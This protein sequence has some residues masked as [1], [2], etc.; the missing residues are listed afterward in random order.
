EGDTANDVGAKI[1]A[2]SASNPATGSGIASWGT[3]TDAGAN[4]TVNAWRNKWIE[5]TSGTGVGQVRLIHSNTATV[6]TTTGRWDTVPDSTSDFKIFDVTARVTGSD[7]GADTTPVRANGFLV[8][9]GQK[10]VFIK[11][12]LVNYTVDANIK[13]DT[14]GGVTV[15]SCHSRNSV[16]MLWATAGAQFSALRVASTNVQVASGGF[17]CLIEGGA[18]APEI[19]GSRFTGDD[20]AVCVLVRSGSACTGLYWCYG[21]SAST[22]ILKVSEN[23]SVIITGSMDMNGKNNADD[24]K[25]TTDV[26][27]CN[28]GGA[29]DVSDVSGTTNGSKVYNSGGWG[30]RGTQGGVC[31][32][33][34]L[35][36][37]GTAGEANVSGDR[38]PA[39]ALGGGTT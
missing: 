30:V 23:G 28:T 16:W 22:A 13:A 20:A 1:G 21:S 2:L 4:W 3:L 27:F 26:L 36:T 34:S 39:A 38:S 11:R 19:M 35:F 17:H 33:A 8:Q 9:S 31:A 29:V 14:N 24:T 12:L 5:I 10:G 37:F 25:V 15:D 32:L 7:S 6:V 18:F